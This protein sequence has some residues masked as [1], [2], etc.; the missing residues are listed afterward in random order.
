MRLKAHSVATRPESSQS[1]TANG[2]RPVV[3]APPPEVTASSVTQGEVASSASATKV[4]ESSKH[5][6]ESR[7]NLSFLTSQAS[8]I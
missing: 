3:S 5:I 6:V 1:S 7:S 8:L 2:N 4:C